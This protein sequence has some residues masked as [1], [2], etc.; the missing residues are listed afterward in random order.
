ML[1]LI[2]AKIPHVS[3]KKQVAKYLFPN[4]VIG[5]KT[6]LVKRKCADEVGFFR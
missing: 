5:F 1:D 2:D 6:V 4:N 3:L